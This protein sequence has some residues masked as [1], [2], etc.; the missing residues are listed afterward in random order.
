MWSCLAKT[1]FNIFRELEKKAFYWP[2]DLLTVSL[3]DNDEYDSP[4]INLAT[5]SEDM[6]RSYRTTESCS[7]T[8]CSGRDLNPGSSP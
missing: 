7:N 4:P 5:W 1:P 8:T 3:Q 6:K 2:L